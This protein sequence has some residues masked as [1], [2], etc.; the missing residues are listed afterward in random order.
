MY[1]RS[2]QHASYKMSEKRRMASCSGF[3]D[4]QTST[5][6][7]VFCFSSTKDLFKYVSTSFLFNGKNWESFLQQQW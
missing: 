2:W 4:Y 5:V 1:F 6:E 7:A 3:V